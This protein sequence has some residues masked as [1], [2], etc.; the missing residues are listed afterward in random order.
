MLEEDVEE[1]IEKLK[2]RR[3]ELTTEMNSAYDYEE[4]EEL[5]GELE[6]LQRQIEVLEKLKL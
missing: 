1:E 2:M 5:K 3:I 4:R 6:K